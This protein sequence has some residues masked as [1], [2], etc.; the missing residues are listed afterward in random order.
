MLP[1]RITLQ[2]LL[3]RK[4]PMRDDQFRVFMRMHTANTAATILAG[5][6]SIVALIISIIAILH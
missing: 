3:I 4:V 5:G 2:G 6:A 1:S